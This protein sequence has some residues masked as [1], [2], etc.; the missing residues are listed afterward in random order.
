MQDSPLFR[1]RQESLVAVWESS[2]AQRDFEPLQ[3]RR[4]LPPMGV[5]CLWEE[6][7]E[8]ALGSIGGVEGCSTL[9]EKSLLFSVFVFPK[10]EGSDSP[11]GLSIRG[12]WDYGGS[13]W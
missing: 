7:G 13:L 10:E 2:P 3:G 8:A 6:P 4:G 5:A 12:T 1:K 9:L 11:Y